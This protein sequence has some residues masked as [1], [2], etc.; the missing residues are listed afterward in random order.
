MPDYTKMPDLEESNDAAFNMG[1]ATLQR[2][3]DILVE[4]KRVS[5]FMNS[6][7]AEQLMKYK[8]LR[9]L[10]L[11]AIVLMKKE[12]RKAIKDKING[13]E[14]KTIMRN[15]TTM[16]VYSPEVD[17]AIDDIAEDILSTL[18]EEGHHFMPRPDESALF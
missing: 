13:V 12:G 1:I 8:L 4:Y 16:I 9:Q 3:N 15:G 5:T 7:G 11:A 17:F 10:Y 18:Q 14:M 6:G 2:I